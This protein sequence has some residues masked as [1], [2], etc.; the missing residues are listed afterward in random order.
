MLPTCRD[1][2]EITVG[3]FDLATV[4]SGHIIR[5]MWRATFYLYFFSAIHNTS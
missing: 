2:I 1:N 4:G 3:Y 5:F